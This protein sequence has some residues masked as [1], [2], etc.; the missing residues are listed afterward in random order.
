MGDARPRGR[1]TTLAIWGEN[2][3]SVKEFTR[4]LDR[5]P[6]KVSVVLVMVQCFG[7]GFADVI[8]NN[9]DETHGLALANRCGF[10]ATLPTRVAA[11]CTADADEENYHEYSTY[12]WAGLYGRTG[13]GDA[14]EP[15][16]YNNDGRVSL[17]ERTLTR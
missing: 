1:N 5:L 7:G 15:P 2:D 11:G 17:A 14:V 13:T 4:F 9:A 8:F 6:P 10:F 12:F 3:M 16:D